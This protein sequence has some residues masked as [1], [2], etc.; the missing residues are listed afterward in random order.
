MGSFGAI[1]GHIA[2]LNCV[3]CLTT[4]MAMSCLPKGYEDE[5]FHL[6]A[7][8]IYVYLDYIKILAFCGLNKHGG[9]PPITLASH[10]KVADDAVHMMGVLYPP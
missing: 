9:T 10:S 1:D 7:L 4:M 2:C 6:L 3:V 8:S 5:R